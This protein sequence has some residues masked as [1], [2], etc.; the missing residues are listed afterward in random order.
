M[1][2]V[3]RVNKDTPVLRHVLTHLG[4]PLDHARTERA[5]GANE[6]IVSGARPH[7]DVLCAG[8]SDDQTAF[9]QCFIRVIH[10]LRLQA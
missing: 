5:H 3:A 7:G 6:G 1:V 8:G 9:S 4:R 2:S 10:H